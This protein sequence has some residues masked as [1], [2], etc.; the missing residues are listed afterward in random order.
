M[1]SGKSDPAT[2][3]VSL[4]NLDA[5]AAWRRIA[6]WLAT[7]AGSSRHPLHLLSV[8]TV[9]AGGAAE[10]RTVVLRGFDEVKREVRFHTDLRSG[11]AAAIRRDAR[12]GLHW[13]DPEARLQIR[14]PATA[15][16]HHADD[17][18]RHGWEHSQPMSRACYL[19]AHRPGDEL[20]SFPPA[21]AAPMDGDDTGLKNF[22]VV[23]CRFDSVELLALHATGHERVRIDVTSN[24][25]TWKILA[26]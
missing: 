11:K 10:V 22:C 2:A 7:A 21:P 1:P 26:P 6:E 19:T 18:A 25:V 5:R 3:T 20:T 16:L 12:V 4:S 23:R 9:D 8:A 13:Y 24:P 15:S 14:I 17:V